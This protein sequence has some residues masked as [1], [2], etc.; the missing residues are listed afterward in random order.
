MLTTKTVRIYTPSPL[1][2]KTTA[3]SRLH[4]TEISTRCPSSW[5]QCVRRRRQL[6]LRERKTIAYNDG[7]LFGLQSATWLDCKAIFPQKLPN[8]ATQTHK[9]VQPIC[10][11]G[12]RWR[13][14]RRTAAECP[15]SRQSPRKPPHRNEHTPCICCACVRQNFPGLLSWPKFLSGTLAQRMSSACANFVS[16]GLASC[17]PWVSSVCV[18]HWNCRHRQ[19]LNSGTVGASRTC[20]CVFACR[21]QTSGTPAGVVDDNSD[22]KVCCMLPLRLQSGPVMFVVG[23][24]CL[25][26]L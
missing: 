25:C 21:N 15:S 4:T 11:A 6:A 22:V 20:M 1:Q 19:Q 9:H 13:P 16:F 2:Q 7:E 14:K 12:V 8:N 5:L 17:P 23:F 10:E 24:L 3:F 18:R 26:Y